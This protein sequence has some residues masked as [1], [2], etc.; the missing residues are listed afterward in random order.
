MPAV[1]PTRAALLTGA[2]AAALAT[3]VIAVTPAGA[4]GAAETAATEVIIV[5][6]TKRAGGVDVQD[7][8]V[9]VTAYG[10][11]QLDARFVRDLE[12]LS[13]AMPNVQLNDIGTARGI[14]N[15]TIRGL[16]I[17][18]SIPSVDP[19]V[20]VFVDGMYLGIN[21]GVVLDTFD[22]DGVEVLRGPQGLLFGRNVT[23]GA[24][25]L[26]S[27]APS[28]DEFTVD[29]KVAVEEGLNYYAMGAASGP[30]TGDG[31]IAAKLALYY[32]KDEGWFENRA[33]G[34]DDFG[35]SETW[36]IR[37]AVSATLGDS[38]DTILRYEHGDTEGDGPPAQN[39]A[40]FDRDSFDFAI[41]NEGFSNADWDQAIWEVNWRVPGGTITNIAGWRGYN[42]Q[43][44]ADID[45]LPISSFHARSL[46]EQEQWS[47][48]L[49]YS[50]TF[51]DAVDLTAGLYYFEQDL[52]Y[53][54]ER[55]LLAFTGA[56]T[57]LT[58]GG[59]LDHTTWGAFSQF[60]LHFSEA[61]TLNVGVRYTYEEKA[62]MINSL[63]INTPPPVAFP[64]LPTS[65][66]CA[67]DAGGCSFATP[68]AGL[69]AGLAPWAS[70]IDDADWENLDG[71]LGFQYQPSDDIQVYG[72]WTSGFRSGGYNF[73]NTPAF[74]PTV[75]QTPGPTEPEEVD[76][77]EVGVK[78]DD[79]SGLFRLN[80]A[81]FYTEI[82]NMQRELNFPGPAGVAQFI[83]NTADAT[84]QGVE[85]E[86]QFAATDTLLFT[87]FGGYTDGSYDKVLFDLSCNG[88]VGHPSCNGVG[89]D[90]L[91][92]DIPRVAPWSYGA[93]VIYDLPL[94]G[95]GTLTSRLDYSHRDEAAYTDNNFGFLNEADMLDASFGFSPDAQAWV[96]S[97]YGRNLLD[98]VT[99][100]GDT[101]L[102]P[103][104]FAAPIPAP[105]LPDGT[106]AGP[107]G[108]PGASFSP[109][110]KGRVIGVE[111]QFR[112]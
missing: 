3:T 16:G 58:G 73:R 109:L 64:G 46:T 93:G 84:L 77:Y 44:D 43:T 82:E 79:P 108:G 76:A 100:G 91:A 42:A 75:D 8:P 96:I 95:V 5:T 99:H 26:R 60:D 88:I 90:D 18:S 92:L 20:G 15:F 57:L 7:V 62:A 98:E 97:L 31:S 111:A 102:P 12:D 69:P 34:N 32:N 35:A 104:T 39:H 50:G 22:L 94:G 47:E 112:Y 48:E 40:D 53:T 101:Q 17:N 1:R 72:F 52:A 65:A 74:D 103:N 2:A 27:R 63:L 67:I 66:S 28:T 70:F 78:Y 55:L 19:T 21:A 41:D 6:A 14:A 89:P 11:E 45:S 85:I 36:I 24:V 80:L 87:A 13:F 51:E 56:P 105:V 54:E 23:G 68:P 37:P 38:L 33:N 30:I 106:L 61:F 107:F 49:R 110:N 10:E 81:G 25:L 9:A 59:V 4:Q 83:R 86:G 71:K 29:G